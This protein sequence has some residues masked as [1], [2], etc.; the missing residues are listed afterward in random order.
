MRVHLATHWT[1]DP[2]KWAHAF[3][4]DPATCAREL[5]WD[6]S[7]VI[8]DLPIYQQ[9]PD[10]IPRD[11]EPT[12]IEPD[13]LDGLARWWMSWTIETTAARWREGRAEHE[14]YADVP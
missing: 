4:S 14:T 9:H 1:V 10:L 6:L 13:Q 11:A 12:R 3:G 5:G 7:A 8:A 2:D